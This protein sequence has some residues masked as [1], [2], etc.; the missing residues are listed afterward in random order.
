MPWSRPRHRDT[1][2]LGQHPVPPPKPWRI[3]LVTHFPS[4]FSKAEKQNPFLLVKS[5]N[6]S[7]TSNSTHS[8]RVITELMSLI[9]G[10]FMLLLLQGIL[11]RWLFAHQVRLTNVDFGKSLSQFTSGNGSRSVPFSATIRP[12]DMTI[13]GVG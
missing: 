12:L 5:K 13:S 9:V 10:N 2:G 3:P 6:P 8:F 4:L 11:K 1:R 7:F